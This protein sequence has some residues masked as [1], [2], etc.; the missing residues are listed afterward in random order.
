MYPAVALVVDPPGH[1]PRAGAVANLTDVVMAQL[2][3]AEAQ[4][5]LCL[6][7]VVDVIIACDAPRSSRVGPGFSGG[8]GGRGD[9][10]RL[11][12]NSALEVQRDAVRR[13]RGL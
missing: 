5:R 7:P 10:R 2:R 4:N 1:R 13:V 12:C 6:N 3:S 11:V 9:Q 8:G